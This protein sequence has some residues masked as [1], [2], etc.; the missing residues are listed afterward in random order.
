MSWNV[1]E[2]CVIQIARAELNLDEVN[3]LRQFIETMVDEGKNK[4]IIDFS[5]LESISSIGIGNLIMISSKVKKSGGN[6]KLIGVRDE[7]ARVFKRTKFEQIAQVHLM[8]Q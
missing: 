8:L 5:D 1:T 7:I 6:L 2:Y 3:R 4:I